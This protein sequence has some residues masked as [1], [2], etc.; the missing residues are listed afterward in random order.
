MS[1]AVG[2]NDVAENCGVVE[3][4]EWQKQK[5]ILQGRSTYRLLIAWP[6][7]WLEV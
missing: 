7:E 6:D 2:T 1:V 3:K 5:D 4:L